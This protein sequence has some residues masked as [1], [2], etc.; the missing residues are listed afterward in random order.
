[1]KRIFLRFALATGFIS[2]TLVSATAALADVGPLNITP[3]ASVIT[4]DSWSLG[5][6]NPT[7]SFSN[8]PGIATE[9][10]SFAGTF[11]GQTAT[12]G[13]PLTL[14]NSQPG[15][16]WRLHLRGP[17]TFMTN[18]GA[19]DGNPVLCGRRQFNGPISILFSRLVAGV[20]LKGGCSVDAFEIEDVTRCG[21]RQA[22]TPVPEASS[23][24]LI[25][26]V[27]I[28]TALLTWAQRPARVTRAA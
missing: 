18:D 12:N 19:L 5:A 9:A 1:M 2:A 14:S 26:G 21:S 3:A 27:C 20:A 7:Y 24:I 10:V 15:G 16:P 11:V 25:A 13:F 4:F 17:T 6:V 28:G 8:M 23:L 22:F